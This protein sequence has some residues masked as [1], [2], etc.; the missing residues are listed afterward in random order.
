M[1]P[2]I[3]IFRFR[4]VPKSMRSDKNVSETVRSDEKVS[5][6]VRIRPESSED[7]QLRCS[8]RPNRSQRH[9]MKPLS[10]LLS[11]TTDLGRFLFGVGGRGRR[12][13]ECVTS[14]TSAGVL[15]F[16]ANNNKSGFPAPGEAF[17]SRRG[18]APLPGGDSGSF[19]A[20]KWIRKVGQ[21]VSN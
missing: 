1:D 4:S 21:S 12:P 3:V 7:A 2:K 15:T 9:E 18:V 19:G 16:E 13:R 10:I 20:P 17:R 6:S 5:E 11:L 8:T 14:E